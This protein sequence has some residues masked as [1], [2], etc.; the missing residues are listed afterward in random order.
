MELTDGQVALAAAEAGAAVVR[1][2]YRT[3]VERHRKI[4]SDF[5]TDADLEAETAIR[6]VLTHHRPDDAQLGEEHGASGPDSARRWLIDPLCGTR[7]FAAGLP[8]M[9][10][11]VA[12]TIDGELTAASSVE[13]VGDESYWTDGEGAWVRREGADAELSPDR[14]SLMVSINLEVDAAGRRRASDLMGD[15][16][17]FETYQPR[18]TSS[19]L[20]LAW[21]AAGRHA[22]YLSEGDLA[23]NVHFAAGLALCRAAGA[24]VTDLAGGPVRTRA[25]DEPRGPGGLL[26]AADE[27]THTSLLTLLS[28]LRGDHA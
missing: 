16:R 17:F 12:L 13:C 11:N 26:A 6:Q 5:A 4:G 10:S 25:A 22:A 28:R 27:E 7:N 9:S 24:V 19:T 1:T 15:P 21:V 14:D 8:L 2:R 18:I 20:A 23:D 3:S